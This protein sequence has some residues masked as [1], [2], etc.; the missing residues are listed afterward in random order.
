VSIV[1]DFT[2]VAY[3]NNIGELS[4]YLDNKYVAIPDYIED[5]TP[6]TA[7][8]VGTSVYLG[9]GD[10][11]RMSGLVYYNGS[12]VVAIDIPD[13]LKVEY[14]VIYGTQE[15]QVVTDVNDDGSFDTSMILPSRVPLNPTMDVFTEVLNMPGLG[16]SA[17][18]S[19]ASV[20]VDSKSPTVLFDQSAY[21]DSSLVLLESDLI[22]DVL[23]TVTMVDEIGM[24]EGPL[25][26]SWA[27][28]RS[29]VAVAGSENTGQLLM[30]DD[31]ES[32]DV[33]Q[34]RIDFTPLNGMAIEQ[35][36]Q[37][38][39]WV[40]S[41][42]RAGNQVTGLGSESAPRMPTLRIMK[43]NPQFTRVVVNPTNTPM[44][45]EMLTLQTF[46]ENDGKRDGSITVG[47]YELN[48]TTNTWSPAHTTLETGPSEINLGAVSSSVIATFQ[49][50]S[51][52]EGQ[53]LLVLIVED[54][55][56]GEMDWEN[57][58]GN[59]IDLTGINVQPLPIEKESTGSLYLVMGV[60]VGAVALVA[61]FVMKNRGDDEYYYE[62]DE[63]YE[64][65]DWEYAED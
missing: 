61:F 28:L 57:S 25:E 39:F 30:I 52:Q 27:I 58:N 2:T 19:D 17:I 3:Q 56:S 20:T 9:Q 65:G 22:N 59:N 7:S 15:I 10:E 33:Y 40:T 55:D 35:G 24:L 49:W 51:W 6:P 60:A 41:T 16:A 29:G 34:S 5:L 63:D 14:T 38:A 18:N 43:F 54:S 36:D 31:G 42:D 11:F 46:W 21:P 26:V 50:E 44:V 13:E 23:V 64:E 4:W 62:D 53:P 45:G 1:D 47:L 12:G 8:A 37:I 32:K 48:P